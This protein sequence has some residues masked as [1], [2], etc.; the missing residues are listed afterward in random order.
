MYFVCA[1]CAFS[2]SVM[3]DFFCDPMDCSLPGSSVYGISQVRILEWVVLSSS[4]ESP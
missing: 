3:S 1:V 4:R 2:C